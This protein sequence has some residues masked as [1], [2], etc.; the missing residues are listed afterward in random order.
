M[1]IAITAQDKSLDSEFDSRFGRCKYFAI[2][3]LET[4]EC[5]FEDNEATTA[6]GGAGVQSAQ[7]LANSGV[8]SVVTG[9]VGPN[10]SRAL[11][12][13]GIKVFVM[14]SGTV[15][16]AISAYKERTLRQVSGATTDSH[17]GLNMPRRRRRS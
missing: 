14:E 17:T 1:K 3:D 11:E 10:A 12:A 13:A 15:Q 2:V 8:S 5:N 4:E 16:D 7:F 9:H 6:L